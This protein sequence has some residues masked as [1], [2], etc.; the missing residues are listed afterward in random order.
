MSNVF[1]QSAPLTQAI[2]DHLFEVGISSLKIT[3]KS[4]AYVADLDPLV[5][6]NSFGCTFPS[7]AKL[8]IFD[9]PRASKRVPASLFDFDSDGRL[10]KKEVGIADPNYKFVLGANLVV[11]ARLMYRALAEDGVLLAVTTPDVYLA[12]RGAL[13]HYFGSDK[14]L[15][16]L[17]Y[18]SRVG[19]GSDSKFLSV[20]HETIL[21]FAKSPSLINKFQLD[22]TSKELEKYSQED[23]ES[24]YYWDTYIRKQARN[25]YPIE[26][27]DGSFLGIDESGNRISWLWR[28]QT[29]LEKL[30]KKDIKF[31]KVDGKWKLYYKDRLKD[32]KILRSLALNS[33]V[34]SEISPDAPEGMRGGDLLNSKGSE[35]IKAFTGKKPD[36]LK[37]SGYF[38][39]LYKV[40]NRGGGR[41][42]IPYPE[43]GAAIEGVMAH[44]KGDAEL[45]VNNPE[46]FK[47]LLQWRFERSDLGRKI[48]FGE[49]S[50][51][52]FKSFFNSGEKIRCELVLNL[53]SIKFG[54]QESWSQLKSPSLNIHYVDRDMTAVIYIE[55]FD[56]SQVAAAQKDMEGM[57]SELGASRYVIF[58]AVDSI[59][60]REIFFSEMENAVV[61]KVP[62]YFIS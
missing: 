55:S 9:S 19:G 35:E 50:T 59:V 37:P 11:A 27:P 38:E 2:I 45:I 34:L 17:V 61:Y 40:F 3:N 24:P 42:I 21:I 32:V 18:Q 33:T 22:K 23:E 25:Y 4:E 39:F 20:D 62:D 8:I 46:D 14:F 52:N 51:H 13:E 10:T 30:G 53:V 15:G 36:Y 5:L 44:T 56:A 29:F 26:C 48:F 54:I 60:V 43:Y 7:S 1:D 12:I 41:V 47:G 28:E 58:C 6:L 57:L 16:E 31:E 49:N